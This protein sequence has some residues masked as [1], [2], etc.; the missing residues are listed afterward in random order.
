MD[1]YKP[2]ESVKRGFRQVGCFWRSE[3]PKNQCYFFVHI[4]F[5]VQ[6]IFWTK[7]NNFHFGHIST[8]LTDFYEPHIKKSAIKNCLWVNM[9][10]FHLNLAVLFQN[11]KN[12]KIVNV[13]VE[14][15]FLSFHYK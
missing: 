11:F 12:Q 5:F 10:H 3:T 13:V 7:K 6:K 15:V 2:L 14:I 4:V 1:R 9:G 8:P